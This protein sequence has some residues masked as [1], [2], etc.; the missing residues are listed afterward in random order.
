[1]VQLWHMIITQILEKE[2]N[3]YHCQS[4]IVM[5]YMHNYYMQYYYMHYYYNHVLLLLLLLLLHRLCHRKCIHLPESCLL[6]GS[7]LLT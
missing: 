1:M 7:S 3:G 2:Q 4:A 6:L 5:H